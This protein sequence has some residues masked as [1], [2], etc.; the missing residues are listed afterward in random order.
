MRSMNLATDN[1]RTISNSTHGDGGQI[2]KAR[3][4]RHGV[5]IA[6][7][8]HQKRVED[9]VHAI[10]W[11]SFSEPGALLDTYGEGKQPLKGYS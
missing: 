4:K 5:M 9:P 6:R 8:A 10:S 7:L 1:L 2:D 11:I 3:N